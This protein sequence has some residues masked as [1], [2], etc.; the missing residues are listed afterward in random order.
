MSQL[1]ARIHEDVKAAMKSGDTLRRDTLRL[2]EAAVKN[3]EIEVGRPLDDDEVREVAV[4]EG[5][6]RRESIEAFTAA[7]RTDLAEREQAELG[8]LS[9]LLPEQLSD[10][11]LDTLI[12][13]AIAETGATTAKEMGRVMGQVMARAKGRVDGAVV[14]AKVKAKLGGD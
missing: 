1:S 3:R 6:R 2:L 11:A 7:G 4:K 8:V 12:D 5:K 10:A 13:E 9:P 14:Q